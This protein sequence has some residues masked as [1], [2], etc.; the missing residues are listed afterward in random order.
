MTDRFSK[1]TCTVPLRT[2][3]AFV[4][5]KAFC[6][7]W[8][9]CYGPPRR[10]HS[11]NGPKFSAKFFQTVCRELV[12]EKDFSS[13][14]HP[15]TNRQVERFNRTIFNSLRGYLA[16]RQGYWDVYTAAI[17]F[18]Y[19]CRINSSL[20]LASFELVLSR[21]PPPLA[22]ENPES[23]NEDTPETVKLRFLQQLREPKPLE[24]ERLAEAQ[25]RY[26]RKYGRTVRP[27]NDG[28]PK[29]S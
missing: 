4:V 16:I 9:F 8:V 27:K 18:G 19:N 15:Q 11:D 22:V 14:Y 5:A 20:G 21:P 29:D 6:E 1:L 13:A 3:T 10:V 28:I 17:T 24:R 26:K 25:G 2:K 23:G 12:I 7:H